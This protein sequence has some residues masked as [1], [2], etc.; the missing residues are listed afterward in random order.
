MNT[1][2]F[3]SIIKADSAFYNANGDVVRSYPLFPGDTFELSAVGFSGTPVID[4]AVTV[5]ATT[6]QVKISA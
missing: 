3:N 1:Y 5:D 6:K 2:E 4:A